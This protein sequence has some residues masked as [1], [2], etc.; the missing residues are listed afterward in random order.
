MTDLKK[1]CDICGHSDEFYAGVASS[2]LGAFSCAW[3]QICLAM[4]AEMTSMVEGTVELCGG[5]DGVHE[6]VSLII[7]DSSI[8]SYVNFRTKEI[9]PI[10]LKN[11]GNEFKTRKE[12]IEWTRENK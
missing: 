5:I 12:F 4:R 2:S 9:I 8:D 6:R 10:T 11:G 1:R 3:C 7:Y